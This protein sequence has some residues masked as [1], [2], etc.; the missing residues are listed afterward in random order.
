MHIALKVYFKM[1]IELDIQ[2][3][4]YLHI[5]INLNKIYIEKDILN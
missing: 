4:F 2:Y 5:I 1:D 3:F